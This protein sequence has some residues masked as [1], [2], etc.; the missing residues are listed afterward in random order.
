MIQKN[1]LSSKQK[2][3]IINIVLF[4]ILAILFFV[5][6]H[7]GRY[8]MSFSET[9]KAIFGVG[10]QNKVYI[11]LNTRMPRIVLA[12]LVGIGMGIA[13]SVMQDIS[14]N[15]LASPGTLGVSAGASVFVTFYIFLTGF[16]G[17]K[18]SSTSLATTIFK[19]I[20]FPVFA[21]FGGLSSAVIIFLLSMR[22]KNSF[23]PTRL[24]M[25]GVAMSSL[26]GAVSL[27]LVNI[28]DQNKIE[29]IQR[30]Q[31]GELWGTDWTYILVLF[32]W[33]AI[34]IVLLYREVMTLNTIKLGYD[35]AKGLGVNVEK[36][37][38]FFATISVAMSSAVVAFGGNFFFLG[39]IGPHI[40]RRMVGSD[41]R[42]L[43]PASGVVSAIIVV[44]A[45]SFATGISFLSNV[46]VG[47][48]ISVCSVPYFIYLLLK[49]SENDV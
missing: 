34:A 47:I 17:T 46:P 49:R 28:L 9:T 22:R 1:N 13:G 30:W 15:S 5:G 11:I 29:L 37:F 45:N 43:I 4:V 26:Y 12:I 35:G 39:L 8:K 27:F 33:L 48:I 36:K 23:S 2:A 40:A 3:L 21:L 41:S 44:I 31:S 7:I 24:I 42:Y 38:F 14:H 25:T 16:I 18:I 19:S 32:L 20:G 6:M 10:E